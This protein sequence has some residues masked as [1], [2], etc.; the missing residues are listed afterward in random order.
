MTG[1]HFSTLDLGKLY[2][3]DNI[4]IKIFVPGIPQGNYIELHQG[5]YLSPIN[6]FV[7]LYASSDI[8]YNYTITKNESYY[9]VNKYSYI[10][11]FFFEVKVN[12]IK[13]MGN[14]VS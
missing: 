7:I 5:T 13:I 14:P 11:R 4:T 1:E 9:I 8:I 10:N 2:E 3:G 12:N 6:G